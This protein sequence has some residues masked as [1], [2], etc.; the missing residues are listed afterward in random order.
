MLIGMFQWGV[1]QS[2]EFEAQMT[3]VERILEYSHLESEAAL[4]AEKRPPPDWPHLGQ[5]TFN[6]V[7]FTYAGAPKPVLSD[8]NFMI[9]GGE[10][11]GIVGRTGAGKSSLLAS[12]FR[13]VEPEGSIII[14]GIDTKTVGLHDLRSKIS[15][16]PQDPVLFTGPVRRNLDPFNEH[17]DD[18][19]WQALE[20]VQL[21]E[22]VTELPGQLDAPIS[23]GGSNFSVGQRQLICLARA[24]LR[25]NKILVLDEATANV[26]HETDSLIQQTIREKFIK[27]TVLTIAH[28]LHTIIDS[29]RVL[30][31]DAGRVIEFEEPYNLLRQPLGLF[32]K[33][34][35]QTGHQMSSRLIATADEAHFK[36]HPGLVHK[37]SL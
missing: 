37:T 25:N 35:K 9:K 1:R 22:V 21:K 17:K 7:T 33:L 2:A 14:D 34:V 13:M 23:E 19:L 12:L 27:C 20:E 3:A 6:G 8:L 28:R 15:I 11:V 30:V 32:R 4:E 18:Q 29:D 26:D 36:R 16:I 10:K 5:I 24:L 31:L